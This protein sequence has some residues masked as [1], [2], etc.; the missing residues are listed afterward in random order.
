[1][2][3]NKALF[4]AF[5]N[6]HDDKAWTRVM[7][8][9]LPSIHAVD[10]TA[11]R[12]WFSFFPLKLAHAL[13]SSPN[14][15]QT[16]KELL[17]SGKYRLEDQIDSSAEFLYGHR[18]W[19]EVKHAVAEYAAATAPSDLALAEH[20]LEVA[21]R[22]AARLN[23]DVSLL[24]GITAIAFMTLQQVGYDAFQRTTAPA[25]SKW[26]KSPDQVLKERN[27]EARGGLFGFL[28]TVDKEFT[29]TFRENDRDCR[30]KLINMQE[31]A[32][33]AA[34]D[35]RDYR[36]RDPRCIEGPIPV[37]CRSAACGSCWVGVLAGAEKLCEPTALE[38]RKMAEYFGYPGFTP[39]KDSIIRLA[40]QAKCYGN[41]TIVIPPWNGILGK[42]NVSSQDGKGASS[43][44]PS[45]SATRLTKL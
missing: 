15:E 32:T 18:Y 2:A 7:V 29:V 21:R 11:T 6:Q 8:Q 45:P 26:T 4:Q 28:K 30:F 33:A 13:Q 42:L 27:K 3:D 41:V 20:V 35:T 34:R 16:A 1:M 36:S 24:V 43:S 31:L 17:L 12:I 39:N 5:L 40:C 38:V 19:P 37:E 25:S 22:T 14:P 9:L 10:Q 44:T 23:V